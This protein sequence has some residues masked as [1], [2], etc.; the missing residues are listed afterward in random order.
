[1]S[2]WTKYQRSCSYALLQD[3]S[4]KWCDNSVMVRDSGESMGTLTTSHALFM[5]ICSTCSAGYRARLIIIHSFCCCQSC[6][7]ASWIGASQRVVIDR[8]ATCRLCLRH[9]LI[10]YAHALSRHASQKLTSVYIRMLQRLIA[11]A[12]RIDVRMI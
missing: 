4:V 11:S 12:M 1:M 3:Y 7:R 6:C 2:R 10:R 5:G 9:S 8:Y